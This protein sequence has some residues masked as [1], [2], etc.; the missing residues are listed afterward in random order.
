M[1]PYKYELYRNRRARHLDTMLREASFVWNHVLALQR[2]YFRLYGRYVSGKRMKSHF[3][4][5]VHRELIHSQTVQE[6]LERLDT[7]YRRFFTRLAKRLPKFR[8]ASYFFSIVFKQ[9][10]NSLC[11]NV[12]T[13]NRIG[14]RFKFSLS[15][16]CD[17]KVKT[18]A[19][20]HNRLG[21]YYIGNEYRGAKKM[22]FI[23]R[24]FYGDEIARSLEGI[25]NELICLRFVFCCHNWQ[26][27]R[28]IRM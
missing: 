28:T 1:I 5:L 26:N 13:I 22:F 17:G 4:H 3:A 9:G 10:S 6:I 23:D 19:V 27:D 25:L 16:P 21:E 18:L 7:A 15:R 14:M 8:T 2:R 12:L 20:K 24:H 11:G